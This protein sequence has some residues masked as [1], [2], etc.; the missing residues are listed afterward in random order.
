MD[1][2]TIE[3]IPVT[4][5]SDTRVS[6]MTVN[7]PNSPIVARHN[8]LHALL[9]AGALAHE[10][11]FGTQSKVGLVKREFLL[12]AS[13]T[14]AF[15]SSFKVPGWFVCSNARAIL[16]L[17]LVEATRHHPSFVTAQPLPRVQAG[18]LVRARYTTRANVVTLLGNG[19]VNFLGARDGAATLLGDGFTDDRWSTSAHPTVRGE[20]T[21]ANRIERNVVTRRIPDDKKNPWRTGHV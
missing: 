13:T 2:A 7:F 3:R 10:G 6:L 9:S 1:S 5:R 16:D 21:N 15:H 18:I 12:L 17:E 8:L 11:S 4:T 20:S 19:V 14:L